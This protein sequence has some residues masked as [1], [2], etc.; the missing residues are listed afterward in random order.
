LVESIHSAY[1]GPLC[2][3]DRDEAD[4]RP[5]CGDDTH[6]FVFKQ[7]SEKLTGTGTGA[8]TTIKEVTGTVKGDAV[9]FR[10]TG[11]NDRGE[12]LTIDYVGKITARDRMTGTIDYH[13]GPPF[14]WTAVKEVK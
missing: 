2:K 11:T 1:G 5:A 10:I 14:E 12:G 9:A 3:L 8:L 7:E 4:T 6:N 13:K